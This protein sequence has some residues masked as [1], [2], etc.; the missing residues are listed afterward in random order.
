MFVTSNVADKYINLDELKV[1]KGL[2]DL[3]ILATINGSDLL[4]HTVLMEK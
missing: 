2:V 3:P 1:D 4:C